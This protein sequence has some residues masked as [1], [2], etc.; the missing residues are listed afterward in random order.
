MN[1]G[2]RWFVV[3]LVVVCT[4]LTWYW[5]SVA[6]QDGDEIAVKPLGSNSLT[7]ASPRP[8]LCR[9]LDRNF[10]GVHVRT[11]EPILITSGADGS[12]VQQQPPQLFPGIVYFHGGGWVYGTLDSKD[13]VID[14]LCA[15]TNS[16][17]VSV[18]YRLAP[19]VTFP[20]PFEDCLKATRCFFADAAAELGVDPRRLA[21][22]GDS[23]GGNLAAAVALRL[24]DDSFL[25]APKL[26]LLVYPVLQGLDF[27][28]PSML[29]AAAPQQRGLT[30]N[31]MC[32]FTALYLE[33][34]DDNVPLY[35][36]NAHAPDDVRR[37]RIDVGRLPASHLDGYVR[38]DRKRPVNDGLWRRLADKLLNPYFSPLVADR[39]DGLPA[40]YLLTVESDPL[41]DEGFLYADRL[42]RAGNNVTHQHSTTG[43]H[44]QLDAR[45]DD[46]I[47]FVRKR[48]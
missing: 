46:I 44:G 42:R 31:D 5:Q 8:S 41:R 38:P 7:A 10:D 39:L 36:D 26:Q 33:G 21:V 23:A 40:A 16:V 14:R 29:L 17:I 19:K 45:L 13:T 11:Y 18:D 24:R 27:Q 12:S 22:A 37:T 28:L 15:A 4:L 47:Q 9:K 32:R 3:I 30:A 34:R 43:L 48:L 35:C 25:P 6:W 2:Q 1:R 20:V